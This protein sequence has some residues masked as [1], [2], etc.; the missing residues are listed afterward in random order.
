MGNQLRFAAALSH[1]KAE[2]NHL[3]LSQIKTC[4]RIIITETAVSYTHLAAAWALAKG[5]L[6]IIGVTK[7]RQGEEAAAAYRLS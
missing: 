2:S 3:P 1:Q 4:P 5:S 6:P 7:V